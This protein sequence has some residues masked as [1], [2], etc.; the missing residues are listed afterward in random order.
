MSKMKSGSVIGSTPVD[1]R[2]AEK[3]GVISARLERKALES[4]KAALH[5][6]GASNDTMGVSTKMKNI[7]DGTMTLTASWF[8]GRK[9]VNAKADLPVRKGDLEFNPVSFIAN[10]VEQEYASPTQEAK[11]YQVDA[12]KITARRVGDLV[13]IAHENLP[14]WGLNIPIADIK[15]GRGVVEARIAS[16]IQ[17]FVTHQFNRNADIQGGVKMP[18]VASEKPAPSVKASWVV[19]VGNIGNIEEETEEA[20]RAT[21]AEYVEQS[22]SGYGRAG[23][24]SVI[25]MED[26]E[27]VEE[28]IGDNIEGAQHDINASMPTAQ[29]TGSKATIT[30]SAS[31][32]YEA[33]AAV[34]GMLNRSAGEAAVNFVRSSLSGGS[35]S[36]VAVDLTSIRVTASKIEGSAVVSV[37]FYG[38]KST[39][40]A[41][42]EVPFDDRGN[43]V[44]SKVG[45]TQADLVAAEDI[46]S[47]LE[48]A[49]EAEAKAIFDKF[50]ADETSKDERFK[51]L[52][53]AAGG[54]MGLGS[55]WIK[56]APVD[57]IPIPKN[58]LPAEYSVVGKKI[59]VGGMVYELQPTDF[60]APSIARSVHWMM[61]MRPEVPA[62][63][64]DFS[65]NNS[66]LGE[67][68]S[69]GGL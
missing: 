15:A 36:V 47:K 45:R 22:K 13:L 27:P 51:A 43:V 34:K 33:D 55:N 16:S 9:R 41:T 7:L 4:L 65:Y 57:R 67:A 32:Q 14:D 40:E 38:N 6:A 58:S 39:E 21:Y 28:H 64:A 59:L 11:T 19:N 42:I 12:S 63:K 25:L 17:G 61:E 24:E 29:D 66:G 30:D 8:D 10:S 68:L 48:V 23:G 35:P 3:L 1:Q 44:A 53:I 52:G 26:G 5:K 54:D 50:V 62:S 2:T 69:A 37:K 20:A 49:S 56:R 60:N 31:R 46:R 18:M